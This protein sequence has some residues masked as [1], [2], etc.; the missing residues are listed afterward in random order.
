[1]SLLLSAFLLLTIIALLKRKQMDRYELEWTIP[2][3][4]FFFKAFDE[5]VAIHERLIEPMRAILGE[6]NL[7]VPYFAR[8]AP[9]IAPA[10]F[11]ALF[12]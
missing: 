7:G 2:A 11:L 6:E 5:I 1:M 8:V 3:G 9:A 10:A 4:G 12:S